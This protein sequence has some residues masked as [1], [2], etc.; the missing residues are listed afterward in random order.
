MHNLCLHTFFTF[1]GE[2][3]VHFREWWCGVKP[4]MGVIYD[5][6]RAFGSRS[7]KDKSPA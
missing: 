5:I 7:G 4:R 6:Q 3:C 1:G 2:T